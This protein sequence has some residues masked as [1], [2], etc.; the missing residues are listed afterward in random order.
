[1]KKRILSLLLVV[2]SLLSL[3]SGMASAADT[4]EGALGEVSIYNGGYKLSYLSV[5]GIVRTME[6][7]YFKHI[8]AAGTEVEIPAYCVNPTTAGVPQ[9][10][11]E[12]ES[13]KYKADSYATD[14][15]VVGIIANGYPHRSLPELGL[16]NKYQ[17]YYATKVALWCY[18]ISNWDISRITVNPNLTGVELQRAQKMLAAVKDIYNRGIWWTSIPQAS[19]TATPDK[20]EAYSVTINGTQYKQ[21]VFTLHSD[22][23]VCDYDI[24]V[25]FTS[26]DDVPEGTRIVDMDNNDITAVTTKGTG[27]GYEDQFK[28]LYPASA[29][30]GKSGSA[31]LTF[32]AKVYKYAVMYAICAEKSKYGT[33]QNY[34]CDTDPTTAIK[35]S[36][37]SKYAASATPEDTP[38][39]SLTILK[40]ESGSQEPLSGAIFEV[41]GPD[42]AV[43]GSF[44]T[45]ADGKIVIPCEKSGMYVVTETTAP[46]YHLISDPATKTVQVVYG[47]AATVTF[48]NAPFG[49]LRVEKVDADTGARLGG[50][51]VQVKSLATGAV[52]TGTT[53]T[54]GSVSFT[55][56]NPGSYTVTEVSAP[57]GYVTDSTVHTI[58][59]TKGTSVT[60]TLK[61]SAKPG[62]TIVKVD[63]QTMERMPDTSF[64]VWHD[65]KLLGTYKTDQLGEISLPDLE[66]GTYL[67]REVAT[68]V[69]HV[70][71]STPQEIELTA[72]DGFRQLIFFN[73]LK[74]GIHLVKVD[75]STMKPLANAKFQIT[76]IGS[77]DVMLRSSKTVSVEYTKEFTTDESGTIDL[78]QLTPGAYSVKEISAP[79]GFLIDDSTRVIQINPNENAQFVFT[80]TPK[81]SMSIVKMDSATGK[82][83]GGATFRI[84]KIEDGSHYLDRVT[85]ADGHISITNLDPGVYSV[86]EIAA[87]AGYVL[88][89]TEYHVELFP[90]QTSQIVV[91]NDQ[92]PDLKII[93]TDS[94]TGKPLQGA[95]FVVKHADGATVTTVTTGPDGSVLVEDLDPG[96]YQI[97]E[98]SAPTG[99]L[100]N[101]SAQLITL[102][103]NRTGT[104]QFENAPKPTLT[105]NKVDSITKDPIKGAKFH[106]T[107]GSSNTFTGEINDLGFF[108]TDDKG[109]IIVSDLKDGWYRVEEVEAADGYAIKDPSVQQAYIAGGESKMLTFE[110]T[111]LNGLVIRK[112]DADTGAVLQG[113]KF[114]LRYFSGVSGTGGTVIGEY[115]TSANGTV[116][117]NRLKAGTY[118][119]EETQAPAGY[120]ISEAAKTVYITGNE[121][122]TIT[123]EFADKSH[124]GLVIQKIDSVTK[125]P[126]A[127]AVFKITTSSGE[128]V[129]NQGG[130]VSSN[131]LYTTDSNG[132]IR[133]TDL[134]PDTYV[135]TEVTAPEGYIL[136]GNAQTVR[137]NEN[138]TQTLTFSNTPAGGLTVVKQ[139]A[140]TGAR[141]KG[142]QFEV[143]KMNGEIIGNYTTDANGVFSLP[144][145]DSGWYMLTELRA[146]AGY[147][148]D[149]TPTYACVKDGQTTTKTISNR[150][151]ASIMIHK[152][153]ASTGKGIYGVKFI[154]YDAG[155]NPIGEYTS[156]QDGWV[157]IKDE[158][159]AGKYFVRELEAAEGYILDEQY[160]TV[161]VEAGKCSQIEWKNAS[162]TGQIQIRKYSEDANTVTGDAAGTELEGAVYEITQ[163]RS[164][165]VIGYITTDAHGIAAS[166]P[167]P[168]GRYFVREVTAPKY[169]QL[170]SEKLEAEIEYAGQIIKL[171]QYDKSAVLGVTIKKVGN[172]EVQPGQSMRYDF[173]GIANTSNVALNSFYWHDRIP[174]DATRAVSMTTGTY[175]SRL[176]YRV[177]YKTNYADYRVLASNLLTTN[178]YAISLTAS[179]LGL[180]TGEYVTDI[181]LEFGSVP[182][183]FVNKFKPTLTVQ[184][185]GSLSNGYQIINRADVG[186]KYLSEW[187]T[188]RTNWVTR[189]WRINTPAKLPKTGY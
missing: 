8:N 62:L 115:T 51:L 32:G 144:Q 104:V 46:K 153:D 97:T 85:D 185:L 171:S 33:L 72:G 82:Y 57:T 4:V 45:D 47:K 11:A 16:D 129:A 102:E 110:N 120:E 142:A 135:V 39:T 159:N 64:E 52:Y 121:Q 122:S 15:K 73:D 84:A 103:P 139:D 157:Y 99:Y 92:K 54:G 126:L 155:K 80:N 7:T 17:A 111:P 112:V 179:S 29:V 9:T 77:S 83:L 71:N 66:P 49:D 37:Y 124:G 19:I 26:P 48:E 141:L 41:K 44:S 3:C 2:V 94:T 134:K 136:D 61:N 95:T 67:V 176:Y 20:A 138:D 118:V 42:G 43:I 25:S 183:G 156:D 186:G 90:G 89:S 107:F 22:S 165:S 145:A 125:Q 149:T 131:G 113:A 78:T 12:G 63:S 5:N 86:Q 123:V 184:T 119:V 27:D 105:V 56:L 150:Q 160:K 114:Q 53:F 18:L 55:N 75:S 21:Q 50:A 128:Y 180:R 1:M 146:P 101:T 181:R 166:D 173:S 58:N 87:P 14:P 152:V 30:D 178:N 91:N 116:V 109:Q 158:L 147:Q 169:Y 174:T 93:K 79:D 96:V 182:S 106:I 177:T 163:A 31:Q 137:V 60:C 154:L 74:P 13:I 117:V 164:G 38:D 70:V 69:N 172:R 68:D 127:G 108:Y 151:T 140:D 168:L 162:V 88:N 148:L 6:Y 24:N 81:P 189:V 133:I 40:L 132:Q 59:V 28:V 175:N 10:V 34:M 23:W 170:N 36:A 98:S 143:R 76:M 130:A 188:A 35:A 187:E 161:W 65:A 167:L 100:L